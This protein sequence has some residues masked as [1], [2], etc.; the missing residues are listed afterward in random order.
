MKRTDRLTNFI[1]ILLFLALLAYVVAFAVRSMQDVTV[2]AEALAVEYQLSGVASGI[3]VRDETVLSS[4]ETYIDV[5]AED[6]KLVAVGATLATAVSSEQGLE[7]LN[8][9][10]ELESEISR[11]ES[12]LAETDTADDLTTRDDSFSAFTAALASSVARHDMDALDT[13]ALNLKTAL[14]GTDDGS[15]SAEHL[16]ELNR[17]LL[18][19]RASSTSDTQEIIAESSGVFSSAVDGYEHLSYADIADITPGA[20]QALI[21]AEQEP[22]DGAYGKL[23][24]GITWYF[25]AV[26]SAEDAENLTEGQNATLNFGRYYSA[27]L[28]AKVVS[29]SAEEDGAAAVVFSCSSALADTLSM[30]SVSADVVFAS[31]DGIRVP[32]EAVQTD[33]E[34]GELYVWTITAMQLERKDIEILYSTDEFVIAARGSTGDALRAGNMIVVSGTDL[35]EGKIME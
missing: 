24:S 3:V 11:V 4:S 8:R 25:A 2:T 32:A 28:T 7:R 12:A 10:H 15:V 33:A 20:L 16:S 30:R 21:T 27:D 22:A 34:T 13:A 35:Y 29:I 31:Y 5:S 26:L 17:E 23:V 6:G 9:M 19:L 1:S 14:I 18:S